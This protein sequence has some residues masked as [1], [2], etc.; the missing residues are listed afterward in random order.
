MFNSDDKLALVIFM[1]IAALL[2]ALGFW[3]RRR[4]QSVRDWAQV[5][6]VITTS[7]TQRRPVARGCE[8][9]LPIIEYEFTLNG[10]IFHS[11]HWR[12]LNF[13]SGVYCSAEAVTAFY[14]VGQPVTVFVNPRNPKQSVLEFTPSYLC[15]VPF[16]FAIFCMACAALVI[17]VSLNK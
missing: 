3:I 11:N 5:S 16:G 4:E 6:G 1:S 17:L 10:R 14:R 9:V 13:S 8:E 15:W 7:T 12:I 2:I